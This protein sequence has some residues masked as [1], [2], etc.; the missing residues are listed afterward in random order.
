MNDPEIRARLH[1]HFDRDGAPWVDEVELAKRRIDM[2]AMIDG[3]LTAIEI[4]SAKDTLDRLAQQVRA[5]RPRFRQVLVV[6]EAD[7]VEEVASTVPRTCGIWIAEEAPTGVFLKR[8]AKGCRKPRPTT[9]QQ[10]VLLA[11]LLRREELA[12]ALVLE[13]DEA[14]KRRD[15]AATLSTAHPI[16]DLERIVITALA[17]R[18][19]AAGKGHL[20]WVDTVSKAH[21]L[22][23]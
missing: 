23:R 18:K 17:Q 14:M 2:L 7:H 21:R 11:Q 1:A 19:R 8:R 20:A 6:A 10:P 16:D 9:H 12:R 4:K 3:V 5:A 13:F 15:L 22:N